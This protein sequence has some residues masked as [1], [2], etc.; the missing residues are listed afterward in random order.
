MGHE[1]V[2]MFDS[3][4]GPWPFGNMVFFCNVPFFRALSCSQDDTVYIVGLNVPLEGKTYLLQTLG[5]FHRD[6]HTTY[7]PLH[8]LIGVCI[9]HVEGAMSIEIYHLTLPPERT[10][11]SMG[12]GITPSRCPLSL[13]P[14]ATVFLKD[15]PI[16]C[17]YYRT[18]AST[19][20]R[21]LRVM[22]LTCLF[23]LF[24]ERR[25]SW[26]GKLNIN[27]CLPLLCL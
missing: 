16:R 26:K 7:V 6:D 25:R 14:S 22:N 12:K 27:K 9:P 5:C 21:E 18:T 24:S 1:S 15:T 23:L 10:K 11:L 3:C 4:D 20:Q 17:W 8:I 2:H 19:I 13:R